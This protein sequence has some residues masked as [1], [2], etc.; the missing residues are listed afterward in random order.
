MDANNNIWP[1]ADHQAITGQFRVITCDT[2]KGPFADELVGDYPTLETA[3]EKAKRCV[4]PGEG[5]YVYDDRGIC[6]WSHFE[7]DSWI[8]PER[9]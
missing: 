9:P 1:V 6:L 3:I 8:E 7:P 2:F 4:C 5:C